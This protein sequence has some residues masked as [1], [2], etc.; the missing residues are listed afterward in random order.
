LISYGADMRWQTYRTNPFEMGFGGMINLEDDIN[1]VGRAALVKLAA[2][3][4]TRR[5]VGLVI[6]GTPPIVG[7]PVPLFH[8]GTEVGFVSEWAVSKRVGH[9]IAV[10]LIAAA[11]PDDA[12]GLTVRI[13]GEDYPVREHSIPFIS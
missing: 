11:L 12:D 5:R 2:T 10:G 7:H 1:F 6:E 8:R 13:D 4:P 3:P 9:V